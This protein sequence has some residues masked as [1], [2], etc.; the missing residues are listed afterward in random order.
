VLL[1]RKQCS[2]V[3]DYASN[4]VFDGTRPL[5]R[6]RVAKL[7]ANYQRT[8]TMTVYQVVKAKLSRWRAAFSAH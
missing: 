8:H 4:R 5:S 2:N 7:R 1:A 6:D 3:A